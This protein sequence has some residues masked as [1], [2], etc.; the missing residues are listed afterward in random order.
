MGQRPHAFA[1]RPPS[2]T[3]STNPRLGVESQHQ[4]LH[5]C[6]LD[7]FL[8]PSSKLA[9]LTRILHHHA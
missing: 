8:G 3:P 6:A 5:R 1:D 9:G 2:L 4:E 7:G